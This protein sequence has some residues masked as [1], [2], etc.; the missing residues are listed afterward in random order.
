MNTSD[1]TYATDLVEFGRI[2]DKHF[3]D[4]GG[5]TTDESEVFFD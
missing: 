4:S 5:W 3:Y 1:K 2:A